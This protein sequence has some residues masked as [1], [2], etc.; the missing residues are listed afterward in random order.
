[1]DI[2][3]K[4]YKL[5]VEGTKLVPSESYCASMIRGFLGDSSFIIFLLYFWFHS[6]CIIKLWYVFCCRLCEPGLVE[7]LCWSWW[8]REEGDAA[9]LGWGERIYNVSR[10]SI[11]CSHKTWVGSLTLRRWLH[12]MPRWASRQCARVTIST[13]WCVPSWCLISSLSRTVLTQWWGSSGINSSS[14]NHLPLREG[15]ELNAKVTWVTICFLIGPLFIY[16]TFVFELSLT[17]GRAR[18]IPSSMLW[19]PKMLQYVATR[20]LDVAEEVWDEHVLHTD[21]LY[22]TYI[23]WYLPRT[24]PC[25]ILWSWCMN[26]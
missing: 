1:M 4:S 7:A 13:G 9:G 5:D 26:T 8:W 11:G 22:D 12:S 17:D 23:R 20:L 21:A 24:L 15:C 19:A 18:G 10:G 2:W 6:Y 16:C 3:L 14:I 25:R